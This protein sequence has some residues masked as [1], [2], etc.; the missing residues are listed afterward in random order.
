MKLPEGDYIVREYVPKTFYANGNDNVPYTYM[1]PEGFTVVKD[2]SGKIV[3]FEKTFH[4]SNN[5][6]AV[7]SQS[8][9]NTR[10]EASLEIRKVEQAATIDRDFRFAI[11]YRGN[12]E[13]VPSLG[14]VNSSVP[15]GHI[16][17]IGMTLT[18]SAISF[19]EK[20]LKS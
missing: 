4:A 13:S 19:T 3:S 16:H 15:T 10:I 7:I 17:T 11:Y 9:T 1:V 12:E 6:T 8:I 20:R 5:E 2:K 18:A 14:Q